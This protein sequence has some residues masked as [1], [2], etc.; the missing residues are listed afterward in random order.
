[1][2]VVAVERVLVVL[3]NVYSVQRVVEL[4]RVAYGLGFSTLV[5]SRAQ[6]AAAQSGVPEAQKLAL[7]KGRNLFYVADLPDVLE[8]FKP[9]LALMFVP[10][11]YAERAFDAGEVARAVAEGRR[12][13][14]VFGGSE[15]GLSR[16]E[17]DMG[18]AVYLEG[19]DDDL[20]AVGTAAI[21]L[22]LVRRELRARSASP[23]SRD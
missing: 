13:A 8:L 2:W 17:L 14:L 23:A 18:V 9:D 7:K 15:P 1:V 20:G 12:V 5:V 6:G 10:R 21:A 3:H 16:R 22:Y 4:A 11:E 19:A